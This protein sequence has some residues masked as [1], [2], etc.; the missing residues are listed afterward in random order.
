MLSRYLELASV[1][2]VPGDI[3]AKAHVD[4]LNFK[5]LVKA[6]GVGVRKIDAVAQNYFTAMATARSR[7]PVVQARTLQCHY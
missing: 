5:K 3:G 2:N 1:G 6:A 7:K 4:G